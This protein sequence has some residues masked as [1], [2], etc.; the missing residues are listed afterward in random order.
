MLR[1]PEPPLVA[2][3]DLSRRA[4]LRGGAAL[5]GGFLIGIELPPAPARADEPLPTGTRFNAF[6]HIA[7]DDTV[8]FTLPAVEMGQGVYTSQAQCLA[9]ELDVGLD[10]VIAA[11]APSDQANYGSPVFIIQA[12]GGSTTTMAWTGPLRKA[13]ATARAM[14]LQAAAAEWGVEAAGLTTENGIITDAAGGR[15]IRY[16]E[17]A[18]R[19]ARLQPPADVKLKD[20]SRF[21]LI[22]KPVHRIDTPDK[23][24]GKAVYGI[25]VMRPG[26]NYATL[27]ASPVLG[28]KVGSV[29]QS[30]A[31]A[32]PGV[33]QVVV[34]EDLVAV[35]GDNTWAAMQG[36]GALAIEWAPGP[37]AG[38]DQAQ[39]W[40]DIEKASE[41]AG[42]VAKKEGDAPARLKDG[43]L[44]EATYELPYLA[45]APMEMTNCTVHV[46]DGACEVWTGTQVPGYA[47]AG[48]AKAL[49]IDPAKV[50]INNHLIG[51]AFGRRLEVD[52]VIKAVRIAAHVEGPVKIVWSREEDI[53]QQLYRPL[54]H[55]RLKARVENGKITAW[56]HRITGGSIM[57][58]WLPP[59]FKNGL[60]VDAV[61][62]TT[63]LPYSVGD[64]LVEYI[65]HESAVPVAFWRGVGPNGSIFS[66]ESFMDLVA[67]KTGADPLA[68]RRG[69]L[70]KSPRALGVL[71]LVADKASWG[72]PAP[73]S[74]FGARRGRGCALMKVFGSYLAVIA[75][76]AVSDQGDVRVT[77]VVVAADVG[78][79]INPDILV[80]QIQGGVTFG[81]SAVLY[82]KI[83]FAGGQVEQGNFNDYRIV[84]IDEMP[85]I[86]VHIVPSGENSGGIGEPGT[87]I[88]QPAVANA[89]FAATGVQLT[90]M[91]IDAAL[92]AKAV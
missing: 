60:D 22:G 30:K 87:V 86:E 49:G 48:S 28:G 43:T 11:H 59:A 81:L 55:D 76:V 88:V 40:A 92:I 54:Y 6:I 74:P 70:D 77:R 39:L 61:D 42:V 14:L 47:Q 41:G 13:G 31:L 75:D 12:T 5:A 67:R 73:A 79:V 89:V 69:L 46:H 8:T 62:G 66:I 3:A 29:D 17:V 37:N 91:P 4:L 65:R 9:E 32:V 53:R 21:R 45:H 85:S 1:N 50:T 35:I 26:M 20:P 52:G 83:T 23:A 18:D 2:K 38:L 64:M 51:G 71:N 56:H 80:A 63:E 90:R 44:F 7:P 19:A 58:R 57:A 78:N 36:L 68:F 84:R 10:K 16:G 27:M 34:L 25:D 24:T 33:R 15:S 72:T 82:G